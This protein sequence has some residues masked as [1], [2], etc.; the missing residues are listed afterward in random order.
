MSQNRG[1]LTS[2]DA[3][4]YQTIMKVEEKLEIKNICLGEGGYARVFAAWDT[5]AQ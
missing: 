5:S 2:K 3:L 1:F 4:S